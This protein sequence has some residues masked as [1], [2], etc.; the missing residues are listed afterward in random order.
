MALFKPPDNFTFD[1]AGEWPSWRQRFTR[2]RT[3][4]KLTE[5]DGTIRV[6]MLIYAMGNEAENIYKSFVFNERE[7]VDDFET[8]LNPY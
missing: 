3:A 7:N 1:K 4:A 5:E 8:V 6:I 2:H